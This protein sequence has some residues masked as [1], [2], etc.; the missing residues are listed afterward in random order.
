[1][2][3]RGGVGGSVSHHL[4]RVEVEFDGADVV[5]GGVKGAQD[6]FS[7]L[8]FDGAADQAIDDLHEGDLD[9]FL[10]FEQGY[11]RRR[12]GTSTVRSMPWWK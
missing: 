10:V 3:R 7:A 6:Q 8:Q 2:A 1:M 5:H 4:F 12:S 11:G 9:G